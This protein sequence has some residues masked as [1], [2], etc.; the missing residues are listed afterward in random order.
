M[1]R[2]ERRTGVGVQPAINI[3]RTARRAGVICQCRP[4]SA[5]HER[6]QARHRKNSANTGIICCQSGCSK[7]PGFSI[8]ATSSQPIET[9]L[10]ESPQKH[11]LV[12]TQQLQTTRRRTTLWADHGIIFQGRVA[13]R[14]T[15]C[16]C[17][18]RTRLL[19]LR[20][21]APFHSDS[22]TANSSA[23]PPAPP[24]RFRRQC[25]LFSRLAEN[26]RRRQQ[27]TPTA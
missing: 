11:R 3:L 26:S 14:N 24:D 20:R 5:Q 15:T 23:G 17:V 2:V 18:L 25:T 22:G 7:M 10:P 21:D 1:R 19:R 27:T 9:G 13:G 16:R 4:H 6:Q 8:Q 12:A